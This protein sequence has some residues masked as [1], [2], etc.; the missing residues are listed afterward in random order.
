MV[1]LLLILVVLAGCMPVNSRCEPLGEIALKVTVADVAASGSGTIGTRWQR[2]ED[3]GP[4]AGE[5]V[6]RYGSVPPI[7]V[8]RDDRDRLCLRKER[9]RSVQYCVSPPSDG[10]DPECTVSSVRD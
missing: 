6:L 10:V 8:R 9:E 2:V 3:I 5:Y 1:D 4:L 7:E